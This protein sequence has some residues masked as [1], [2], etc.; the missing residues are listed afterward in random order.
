MGPWSRP[1]A[2]GDGKNLAVN[3]RAKTGDISDRTSG[4][5]FKHFLKGDTNLNLPEAFVFETGRLNAAASGHR[6]M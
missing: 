2:P 6:P 4:C 1:V 3:F 5:L